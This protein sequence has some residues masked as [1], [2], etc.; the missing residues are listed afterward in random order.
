MGAVGYVPVSFIN[1]PHRDYWL[2]PER[3][4]ATSAVM[5]RFGLWLACL[6]VLFFTA[7]YGLVVQANSPGYGQHLIS[8]GIIWL[9]EECSW[10]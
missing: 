1:L 2:A 7:L 3:R 8:P 5:L 9:T 4:R 10:D 6:M